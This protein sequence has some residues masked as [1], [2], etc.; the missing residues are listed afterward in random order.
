MSNKNKPNY[1][2]KDSLFIDLFSDKMRLIQLYKS[3]IDD[4][5]EISQDDIEILTIQNI[6]LRGIYN[7]LGFRVK[8]EIIIL[9][10]A[11]TTY[12]TNI[13]LRIL[14]YLS[15]TLKNYIT[16]SSENKNL[17][18]LYNTK[19]RIIPKIKLFVVY[20]GDKM[21]QDHDLYLKD[22]MVEND[23]IS[24][25]DMKVRVLCTG[26]K[27][28]ILG[29]YI[30][31]TQIYTKQKKE[32]KDIETAVKNTIEICMNDEILKEYLDYRKME[33]QEMI[34]AFTTQ[35]EAFESFLKDEVKRGRKEGEK[36]GEKRG[37]EKG[38]IDTL[39]N[40]FKNGAGLDLISKAVDMSIDEVKSILIGRGFEV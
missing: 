26:S 4:D 31:F 29:Q 3:L 8:D 39:I 11:Q 40:F 9:M 37:E 33:V 14:F 17:N 2:L 6:I 1:T 30:L 15:E 21:M 16:D 19:P 25:I 32:C 13:V 10:E 36:I 18:E 27:G 20:T 12:T 7:D 22:V 35:E 23:I 38:K 34:T 5:R 24:D 28:S